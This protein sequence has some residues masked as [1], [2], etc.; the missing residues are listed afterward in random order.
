MIRLRKFL[1]FILVV[2]ACSVWYY[3]F[4]ESRAGLLVHFLDVGQGD[5][6]F[7]Q[8][9]NGNQV[10][11]DGGPGN[12]VLSELQ[13]IMPFYD[14]FIDMVVL[15]HPDAD[16]LGGL[17]E[18]MKRY[19]VGLVLETG[20]EHSSALFAE[21][22]NVLRE[23]NATVRYARAGQ[24]VVI[25]DDI[26]MQILSPLKNYK[27]TA[28]EKTNNTSIVS[29]LDYGSASFLFMGDAEE[30][31]EH[32]LLLIIPEVLD[33]DILKVGHHGSKTSTSEKFLRAVSPDAAVI[34]VGK[35]NR[36][37]HPYTEVLDRLE[38]EGARVL[39]TD[40]DGRV[41]LRSDGK[42]VWVAR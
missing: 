13:N 7:I 22:Q 39:R 32:I 38:E 8:A 12:A 36:Y 10:L 9:K 18:V 23:S 2:A 40:V 19:R 33:T 25:D 21:W 11:I 5:S 17:V 28:L 16:H 1:I 27:G 42:T 6:I 35:G 31:V 26:A 14:R 24:T 20:V 29:R 3:L 41:E 4:Q 37:G 30:P 15:T 34:S